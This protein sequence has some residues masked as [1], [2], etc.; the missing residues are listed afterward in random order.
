M[1]NET[2]KLEA[3]LKIALDALEASFVIPE[4]E[5]IIADLQE[6]LAQLKTKEL[7]TRELQELLRMVLETLAISFVIPGEEATIA[8][9]RDQLAELDVPVIRCPHCQCA[10]EEEWLKTQ[11]ASLMGRSKGGTAKARSS[12]QAREAA[13]KRWARYAQTPGGEEEL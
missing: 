2:K 5:A 11:G 8:E 12:E 9:L 10:L 7:Q 1:N 3:L 4:Q 6:Q 13:N